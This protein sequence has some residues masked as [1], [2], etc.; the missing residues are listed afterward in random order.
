VSVGEGR[1]RGRVGLYAGGFVLL[2]G[3]AYVLARGNIESS[4]R[5]VWLSMALSGLAL[6]AAVLSVVLPARVQPGGTPEAPDAPEQQSGGPPERS[7]D[8]D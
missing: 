5:F 7:S 1:P 2:A 3:S 6:L 4:L 8:A